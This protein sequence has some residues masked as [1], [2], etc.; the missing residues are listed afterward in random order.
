VPPP[1]TAPPPA[2]VE[3]GDATWLDT[4]PTGTCANNDAA[5]GEVISVTAV[6]TGVTVT[7]RVVSRGPYGAGRIVD[8]AEATFALLAPP[9]QGV[10]AVRVSW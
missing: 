7:C 2:H 6:G 1:T 9:S 8:L 5:M 3:S 4:I 10:V